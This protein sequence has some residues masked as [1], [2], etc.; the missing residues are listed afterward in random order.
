MVKKKT[1]FWQQFLVDCFSF[2]VANMN[3]KSNFLHTFIENVNFAKILFS[4]ENCRVR[5][6]TESFL[7]IQNAFKN[8]IAKIAGK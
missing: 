2:C 3:H 1:H 7:S 8:V 6:F 4:E 5:S